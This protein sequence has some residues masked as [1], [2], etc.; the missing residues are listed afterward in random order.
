MK[1]TVVA[2]TNRLVAE[3]VVHALKKAGFSVQR[4]A[5]QLIGEIL[6]L[7]N[8]IFANLLVT[9]SENGSFDMRMDAA[10]EAKRQNPDIK[11]ALL[12][13]NVSDEGIAEK[14]KRAKEDGKIDAFFYESVPSDYMTAVLDSL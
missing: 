1:R 4:C 8:S 7:A 14:V 11:V 12:C 9:R 6:T 13:D 5:S 3:A 2:I 10:E